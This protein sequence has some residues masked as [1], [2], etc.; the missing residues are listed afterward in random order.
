MNGRERVKKAIHFGGP[1]RI[2]LMH[3][4]VIGAWLKYGDRLK[5][6]YEK[7]PA[8]ITSLA[9]SSNDPSRGHGASY[10]DGA[11]GIAA[12]SS[13]YGPEAGEGVRD[14][15][16][17]VWLRL[18]DQYKGQ[19]VEHPLENWESLGSYRF[20]DPFPADLRDAVKRWSEAAGCEKYLLVDGG[21]LFQRMFYLRGFENLLVDLVEKDERV[22]FLRDRILDHILGRIRGCLETAEIDGVSIRDDW[23]AQDRL[24]ISP[25]MW[26]EIFK[27]AYREICDTIQRGGA[28]A[29]L[30]TDGCTMQIIPDLIE[31]GF[32]E[33]NPQLS[34]MKMEELA[35]A[36]GGR[37]CLRSDIDRQHVLPGKDAEAVRRYV[38][39]VIGLFGPFRGGLIGCGEVGP[40][41]PLENAEAMLETFYEHGRYPLS[42]TRP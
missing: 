29:H 14:E 39:R 4:T 33:L 15:W 40:D 34:V 37:V 17:A 31:V 35:R 32:D 23:G 24:L 3:H 9:F 1:D 21:T 28:N 5:Q 41:V 30:H 22:V 25:E 13:E 16:G 11:S 38:R 27:P 2:P 12:G 8:D 7:Y 20:P 6:L 42:T 10:S 18:D 19:V 36:V 26:R